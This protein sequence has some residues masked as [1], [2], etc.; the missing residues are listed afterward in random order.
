M[1][2]ER[3]V[4]LI[5][6]QPLH[7][8]LKLIKRI[9]LKLRFSKLSRLMKPVKRAYKQAREASLGEQEREILRC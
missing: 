3:A 7:P 6:S 8:S 1:K 4:P 2:P 9:N 5:R